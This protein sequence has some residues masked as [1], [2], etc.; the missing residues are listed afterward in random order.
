MV[1]TGPKGDDELGGQ[2]DGA[3]ILNQQAEPVAELDDQ[4]GL[5]RQG[6]FHLHEADI[7]ANHAL[8]RGGSFSGHL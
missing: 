7:L 4:P 8:T 3:I 5:D 2:I 6:E 1:F